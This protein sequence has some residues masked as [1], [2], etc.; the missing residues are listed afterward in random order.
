MSSLKLGLKLAWKGRFWLVS[1][2]LL[3][4]LCGVVLTA[5]QFSGR[6]PATVALD[7]GISF[8]RLSLA[9]FVA[10]LVQELISK[11]FDRRYY[12]YSLSYPFSRTQFVLSRLLA[13]LLIV[14]FVTVCAALLLQ[15]LVVVIEQGYS[16]SRPVSLGLNYWLTVL[17]LLVDLSVVCVVATFLA[18]VAKTPGFVLIGTL[19]FTLVGRSYSTILSLLGGDRIVVEDPEQY[20]DSLSLVSLLFPDL[21][22]LDVR[23]IALYG[24]M[25]FLP[26]NLE[27]VLLTIVFYVVA[28]LGLTAWVFGKRRFI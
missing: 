25:S 6:Q 23:E 22:V 18:V 27:W 3:L 13:A 17:L 14:G 7:V 20:Q 4:A 11:E 15:V 21:G 28:I 2:W 1:V 8:I 12:L 10:L 5:A 19:G 24:E 9:V 26:P 16:Q